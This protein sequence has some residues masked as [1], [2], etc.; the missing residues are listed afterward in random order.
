[1]AGVR[2][3]ET[4]CDVLIAG[5]GVAGLYAALNLPATYRVVLLSKG[6]VDECDSMLAQGG[7]CVLPEAGDYQAFFDDTLRAGHGE[8]RRESVDIMIR[9]SRAVINDLVALGVDFERERDGSLAFTREGAH[10]RPRICYRADITGREIT[11][12]L[13]AQVRRLPN[14]EIWEHVALIDVIEERDATTGERRCTGALVR[15]VDE[16]ESTQTVE[17]LR[18]APP[19]SAAAGGAGPTGEVRAIRARATILACGGIGGVYAHSTNYPQLT[20]DAC[21]IAHEHGIALENSDYVQIHPT[22]LYSTKPGRTFSSRRAAVARARS[23]STGRA[24][25]SATSCSRA[26]WWPRR[27]A[28]RCAPTAPTTNG[29]HSRRSSQRSCARILQTS[30][31]TARTRR[32]STSWSG[33]CPWSPRSI[34]L[35]AAS[36]LTATRQRRSPGSMRRAR[37]AA[38]ACTVPTGWRATACSGRSCSPGARRRASPRAHRLRL[39][40][41]ESPRSTGATARR[42]SR[43]RNRYTVR[44]GRSSAKGLTM[45]PIYMRLHGDEVLLRALREDITYEDVST[46]AV[47][48]AARPAC[49]DLIAKAPGVIA[50]LA[51]F[52]RVFALLDPA[53]LVEARVADGDEVVPGELLATVR[54]DARVLLSGERVALNFLQ[55]MSGIATYTR[56]MA[57]ALEGT[58]TRLVDTRKT[59]P[60][61]RAFERAAVAVGGGHNHRYNLSTAVMLKDN[62]IDAAGGVAEAVAAARERAP[63]TCTVEVE[64]EN[65][66][67]V[68]EAVEAAPIS[69]CSIT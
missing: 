4:A 63:F 1:M 21:V 55:R 42:A 40:R 39:R 45:D 22:G 19:C 32:A 38:T 65:L 10:S 3:E 44:S 66:E 7:I 13:L 60:G 14:V 26:T 58:R 56:R 59:T 27:S 67:M 6:A 28:S 69:S 23:C 29:C 30:G 33:P 62:H 2:A 12:K 15:R 54:G 68:R 17:E 5:C 34:T 31:R 47:C 51:V 11:T 16:E 18:V 61:L 52:E 57:A 35:W 53:T 48:P 50:G 8:N 64:C 24:S 37:R 25:A 43:S 9:S 36:M 20:G 49:V 46:D 41:L